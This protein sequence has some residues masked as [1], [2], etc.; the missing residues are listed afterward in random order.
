MTFQYLY[1]YFVVESFLWRILISAFVVR[2][3]RIH[4]EQWLTKPQNGIIE[5]ERMNQKK[6]TQF[7]GT[8]LTLIKV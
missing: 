4:T 3:S 5:S 6:R 7:H 2:E 8:Q 1:Y